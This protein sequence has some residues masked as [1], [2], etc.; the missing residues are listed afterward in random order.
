MV[1]PPAEVPIGAVP[2]G[3]ADPLGYADRQVWT[4]RMLEAL[5][6]G[7][8]EGGRWYW[9]HDKVFAERTLRAAFAQVSANA[10]APGVDGV[11]VEVFGRR[12]EEEIGRIL[13]DWKAERFR[14]QAVRRTWIPKPGSAAPRDLRPARDRSPSAVATHIRVEFRRSLAS[15]CVHTSA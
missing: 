8:P 7:G 9:L 10:G 15:D 12:L 11:T 14:P 1:N 2:T 5:R 13:A 6:R 4:D 3:E